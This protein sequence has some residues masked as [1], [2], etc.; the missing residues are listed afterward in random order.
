[1]SSD[2]P[3][4][5]TTEREIESERESYVRHSA[6]LDGQKWRSLRAMCLNI[7]VDLT[8]LIIMIT[9]F[10]LAEWT[11]WL[12][13]VVQQKPPID[14]CVWE[15]RNDFPPVLF[16]DMGKSKWEY[17][18][19]CLFLPYILRQTFYYHLPWF[20]TSTMCLCECVRCLQITITFIFILLYMLCVPIVSFHVLRPGQ[21]FV[22]FCI[23]IYVGRVRFCPGYSE[24]TRV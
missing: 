7:T 11:L 21:W 1:M 10:A 9:F 17:W 18:Y 3:K 22:Y 4:A 23:L 6:R 15:G 19:S 12:L 20:N 16:F 14:R 8:G 24:C 13:G 5:L 2:D